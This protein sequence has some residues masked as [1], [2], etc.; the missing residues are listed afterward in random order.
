MR[1]ITVVAIG[2]GKVFL[3]ATLTGDK[4]KPEWKRWHDKLQT[5]LISVQWSREKKE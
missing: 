3:R 2:N 1:Q 5:P 4:A